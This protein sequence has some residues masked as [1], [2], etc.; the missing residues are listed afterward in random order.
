MYIHFFICL[1]VPFA[2]YVGEFVVPH[3]AIS[4]YARMGVQWGAFALCYFPFYLGCYW[5]KNR[6][7]WATAAYL[8]ANALRIFGIFI[9]L[10]AFQS[11]DSPRTLPA[12][13]LYAVSVGVFLLFQ[14]VGLIIFRKSG[15]NSA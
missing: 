14:L 9:V 4:L 3:T 7:S 2:I 6:P 1:A 5:R 13:E 15:R 11:Y 12:L 8:S 10:V